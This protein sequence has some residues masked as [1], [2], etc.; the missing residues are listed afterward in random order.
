[1][2]KV[3]SRKRM[4]VSLPWAIASLIGSITSLIPFID[5]PLTPDQVELLKQD[6][7][8]SA[9]AENAD[10]DLQSMGIA[11]TALEAILPTYLVHYRPAGQYTKMNSSS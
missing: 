10:L 3:I 11:P 4:M 2:L 9:D 8:V 1:M 7:V 6:N 5:P